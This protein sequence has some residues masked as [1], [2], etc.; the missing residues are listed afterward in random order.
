MKPPNPLEE[1]PALR[2]WAYRLVWFVGLVLGGI[3][4]WFATTNTEAPAWLLPALAV[5]GYVSIATN[6]TADRNVAPKVPPGEGP[7]PAGLN[8][9]GYSPIEW[10]LVVLVVLIIL[11][12]IVKLLGLL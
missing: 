11:I 5:L 3:Q 9:N 4:I 6:Y 1:Y 7:P 8:E 12:V 10:L 2:Q